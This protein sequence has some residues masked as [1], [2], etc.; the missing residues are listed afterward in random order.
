VIATGPETGN[1]DSA[2]KRGTMET[3]QM[4]E[5]DVAMQ[6]KKLAELRQSKHSN[7]RKMVSL[8]AAETRR[9]RRE[10]KKLSRRANRK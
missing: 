2:L 10:M 5:I 9:V 6:L 1:L 7:R 3:N 4:F 8:S